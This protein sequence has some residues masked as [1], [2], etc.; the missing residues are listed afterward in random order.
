MEED[1]KKIN[2]ALYL[3]LRDI[4]KGIDI[5]TALV[6]KLVN[7]HDT[8]KSITNKTIKLL[9]ESVYSLTDQVKDIQKDSFINKKLN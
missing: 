6:V 2:E 7:D 4:N 5:L 8:F 9:L 3:N 1:E